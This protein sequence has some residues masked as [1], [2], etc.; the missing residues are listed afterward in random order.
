MYVNMTYKCV[1]LPFSTTYYYILTA[2]STK[3]KRNEILKL[4]LS[5]IRVLR[6]IDSL[7]VFIVKP[8]NKRWVEPLSMAPLFCKNCN[9]RYAEAVKKTSSD[10]I[11]PMITPKNTPMIDP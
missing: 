3:V 6:S 5:Q 2:A 1:L 11:L 8:C 4:G 10:E 9:P 7:L